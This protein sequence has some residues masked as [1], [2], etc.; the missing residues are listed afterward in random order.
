MGKSSANPFFSSTY[1]DLDAITR[2]VRPVY[3][4][5][6]LSF[7]Q[8]PWWIDGHDMLLTTLM[9]SSGQWI[10]SLKKLEIMPDKSGN[11]TAQA[12][13]SAL[14][15]ARR[16]ALSGL[17]NL[18]QTDEDDDGNAA[19][20]PS[21]A[22]PPAAATDPAERFQMRLDADRPA[23]LEEVLAG[24]DAIS[25][26]HSLSAYVTSQHSKTLRDGVP[27]ELWIGAFEQ[28]KKDIING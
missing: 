24:I 7:S 27:R 2:A 21:A 8:A 16:Y 22:P 23:G 11:I 6:D 20:Q 10:R 1:A 18:A 15:Y 3:A 28:K 17:A 25:S 9:H 12:S 26:E 4:K 19:S 14:T 5:H 13:G